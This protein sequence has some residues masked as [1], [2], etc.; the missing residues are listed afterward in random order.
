MAKQRWVLQEIE[1]VRNCSDRGNQKEQKGLLRRKIISFHL[2]W[3]FF[4]SCTILGAA[5]SSWVAS[6]MVYIVFLLGFLEHHTAGS[7]TTT[8][9]KSSLK[10]YLLGSPHLPTSLSKTPALSLALTLPAPSPHVIF[11]ICYLFLEFNHCKGSNFFIV[12]TFI[13]VIHNHIYMLKT[14]QSTQY[15][16]IE[17]MSELMKLLH[18]E[19]FC[20]EER[21]S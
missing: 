15:V 2:L 14:A 19:L 3:F 18:A 7:Y 1:E 6:F 10:V 5:S 12:L 4:P 11:V 8:S 13:C 17:W 21:K 16:L 9:F 20:N